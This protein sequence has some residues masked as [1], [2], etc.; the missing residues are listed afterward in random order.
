MARFFAAILAVAAMCQVGL[1]APY[2]FTN[3]TAVGA[4]PAVNTTV[5]PEVLKRQLR[6]FPIALARP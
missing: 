4:T 5:T 2:P 6:D 3:G 1:A